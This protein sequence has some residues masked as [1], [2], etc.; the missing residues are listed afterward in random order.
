LPSRYTGEY[1][2]KFVFL[3]ISVPNRDHPGATGP[4]SDRAGGGRTQGEGKGDGAA[5]THGATKGRR[6]AVR[7]LDRELGYAQ[8]V[9]NIQI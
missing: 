1:F 8:Q 6:D 3:A 9:S 7:L 2:H 5:D 4:S